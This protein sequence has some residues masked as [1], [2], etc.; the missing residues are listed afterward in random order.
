MKNPDLK[1]IL[2]A[3][4]FTLLSLVIK[5]QESVVADTSYIVIRNDTVFQVKL[6]QYNTGRITSDQTP[7][8]R[9]T[10]SALTELRQ[11][12]YNLSQQFATAMLYTENARA[13]RRTV[14]GFSAAINS[15]VGRTYYQDVDQQVGLGKELIGTY[16]FRVNGST[17][18]LA[19]V[20]RNAQGML[21]FRVNNTNYPLD[22]FSELLI[23]IRNYE[24]QD[25]FL[26]RNSPT[27]TVWGGGLGRYFLKKT[28]AR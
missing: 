22:I 13:F 7:L 1:F 3:L 19:A 26:V 15:I 20:I 9:D 23:Y 2:A 12:A 28:N 14:Q 11:Q 10:S 21:R 8:G 17:A 6:V 5:A 27:S 4:F 25:I 16:T 24:G 18:I